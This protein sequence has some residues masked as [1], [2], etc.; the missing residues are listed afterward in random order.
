MPSPDDTGVASAI[1]TKPAPQAALGSGAGGSGA[2]PLE[3]EWQECRITIGRFDTILV[4]LRK[5][6]FSLVT[7][8]LGA[9]AFIT[10][11]NHSINA[12]TA[13][14][15]L[16]MVLITVLYA[17]DIFYTSL[18]NGAVERALDLEATVTSF[19]ITKYLSDNAQRV[20]SV[21]VTLI[22]YLALQLVALGLA[23]WFELTFPSWW[24]ILAVA[25]VGL[26]AL[27]FMVWYWIYANDPRKLEKDKL[28]RIWTLPTPPTI[29]IGRIYDAKGKEPPEGK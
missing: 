21:T 6:G 16:I 1:E 24:G 12:A 5:F 28:T 2:G 29:Q 18:L 23:L 15:I 14:F 3:T 17:M 4:D 9:S 19:R 27:V 22:V 8:L 11:S 10:F 7:T 25:L 13:A 26:A 20:R